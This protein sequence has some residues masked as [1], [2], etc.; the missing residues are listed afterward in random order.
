[1][2]DILIGLVIVSICLGNLYGTAYGWLFFG[3]FVLL[4]GLYDMFFDKDK[5]SDERTD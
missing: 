1:M 5:W 4:A 3:G 2:M